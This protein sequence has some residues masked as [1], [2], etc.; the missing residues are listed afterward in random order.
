[1][2]WEADIAAELEADIAGTRHHTTEVHAAAQRES[3]GAF[4]LGTR[5]EAR[6]G[7]DDLF[8]PCNVIAPSAEDPPEAARLG[9]MRVRFDDS[10]ERLIPPDC[11]I[12][13]T[14]TV[15]FSG[16]SAVIVDGNSMQPREPRG[17]PHAARFVLPT[18][19]LSFAESPHLYQSGVVLKKPRP[20]SMPSSSSEGEDGGE[21]GEGG[22]QRRVEWK[23]EFDHTVLP[24]DVVQAQLMPLAFMGGEGGI[25]YVSIGGGSGR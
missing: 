23:A 9:W 16:T 7:S 17:D 10:E 5:I 19:L 22:G 14:Q 25:R 15:V 2:G 20:S 8:W 6:L 24:F 3:T 11:A 21:G 4:A 12:M 18:R 1:M 13:F